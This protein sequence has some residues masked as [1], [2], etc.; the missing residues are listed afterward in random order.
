MVC[1]I[2]YKKANKREFTKSFTRQKFLMGNH[3]SFSTPNIHAIATILS[4]DSTLVISVIYE[5]LI[6]LPWSLEWIH[7][8]P[9]FGFSAFIERVTQVSIK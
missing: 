7:S 3:K 6:Y 5:A 2:N 4:F 9:T 8:D 1:T